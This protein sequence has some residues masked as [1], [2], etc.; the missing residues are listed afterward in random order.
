MYRPLWLNLTS[1]MEEI[2]SEKKDLLLGSSGSSKTE[3]HKVFSFCL[4]TRERGSACVAELVEWFQPRV[5]GPSP[6]W[7]SALSLVCLGFSPRLPLPLP[8]LT[9]SLK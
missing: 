2:I 4:K 8:L 7:G 9:H 3:K 6:T 1:E 5:V